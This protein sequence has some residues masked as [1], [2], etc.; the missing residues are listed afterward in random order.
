MLVFGRNLGA[1]TF[2]L[3][4]GHDVSSCC[5]LISV[6]QVIRPGRFSSLLKLF[7]GRHCV[8]AVGQTP[9]QVFE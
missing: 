6:A 8:A 1:Q 9:M 7:L 2:L 4:I 5:V 3:E